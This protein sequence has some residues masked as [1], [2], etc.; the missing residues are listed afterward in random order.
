MS[1]DLSTE[2]KNST[3]RAQWWACA[4]LAAAIIVC[5]C[6]SFANTAYADCSVTVESSTADQ[7]AAAWGYTGNVGYGEQFTAA[8]TGYVSSVD[9]Y[10]RGNTGISHN[11]MAIDTDSSG[12]PGSDIGTP[13][14]FDLAGASIGGATSY[15][16]TY[17][18]TD[19]T[20][21]SGGTYWAVFRADP[22]HGDAAVFYSTMNGDASNVVA[23][24]NDGGGWMANG[25][26]AAYLVLHI[27][28]GGGGGGGGSGAGGTYNG[29]AGGSGF[30]RIWWFE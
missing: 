16:E 24:Y 13:D 9:I 2:I 28:S 25:E 14:Q 29:A 15:N 6:G 10:G 22:A 18:T 12:E 21:T 23:S 8:C 19:N 20:V 7:N 26:P 27:T 17:S 1:T 3:L 30:A 4:A 5:A 11:E